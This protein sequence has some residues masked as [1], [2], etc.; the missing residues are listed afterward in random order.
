MPHP[1]RQVSFG[2]VPPGWQSRSSPLLQA[3]RGPVRLMRTGDVELANESAVVRLRAVPSAVRRIRPLSTHA[4]SF[5]SI[6]TCS[7]PDLHPTEA[8]ARV[9][10]STS[11]ADFT[12]VL[13]AAARDVDERACRRRMGSSVTGVP[14]QARSAPF[15]STGRTAATR[16]AALRC[17]TTPSLSLRKRSP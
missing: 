3:K 5:L 12:S 10:P 2:I 8:P 4:G 6:W 17:A 1:T 7:E 13:E 15:T 14:C 11:F 16:A 9:R